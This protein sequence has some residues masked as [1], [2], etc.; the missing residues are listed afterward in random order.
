MRAD[1]YDVKTVFGFERQ[2]FTLFQR[3]YVW[4]KDDQ[5]EPFLAGRA[6]GC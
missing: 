1:P 6:E 3:P 5:W 4:D 2:L